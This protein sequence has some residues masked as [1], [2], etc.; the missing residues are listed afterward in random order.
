MSQI[1]L[2]GAWEA[3]IVKNQ[4]GQPPQSVPDRT[5]VGVCAALIQARSDRVR[6]VKFAVNELC[7]LYGLLQLAQAL[8]V[9]TYRSANGS[10][11]KRN[12]P[13]FP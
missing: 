3:G 2:A 13:H 5:G 4:I 8:F 11:R 7:R 10:I 6:V 12:H 1:S 9:L